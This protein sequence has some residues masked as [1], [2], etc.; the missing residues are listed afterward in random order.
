MWSAQIRRRERALRLV[1]AVGPEASE[2]CGKSRFRQL[3]EVGLLGLRGYS[4]SDYYVLGLYRDPSQARNFMNR[5]QFDKVRRQWNP[6]AQGIFE[7][8]KWIFGHYCASAGIPVPKSFG[9]FHPRI[10]IAADGRPLR[11]LDDLR[12]VMT[13]ANG[14]LAI[15]P[16]AGSHGDHVMIIEHFDPPSDLVTRASGRQMTCAALH[17]ILTEKPFPWIL[18]ERVRQHPQLHELHPSSLNT[19][20]IITL[21]NG[22][23]KA[24]VLGAVLRM[25][26]G[27]GEVDNTTSGGIA[28]P[29]DLDSGVCGAAA[30]EATIRRVAR[31]P[32]SGRPIEGF[33][34]P[35][36]LAMKAAAS[37]AHERL[38]F[39][40]SLGW[41]V[42]LGKEG[43]V[44]L[45]VNGT[46]YQNHVQMTGRS[47]WQTAFGKGPDHQGGTG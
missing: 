45:E 27:S 44:I 6:P 36:W 3:I 23:G 13:A 12:G 35:S 22:T 47:L 14:S 2:A 16:V 21:L 40:R 32:D 39:A 1:R 41:D 25:G 34:V 42:A 24:Q 28:A 10:G 9:L 5:G 17:Q 7:F 18:Q 46:W 37:T 29:V 11:D 33:V 31:H 8:N 26:T 4:A 20:R 43:P 38:P 30:S 15:K 19:C